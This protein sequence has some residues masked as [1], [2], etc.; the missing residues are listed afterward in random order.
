MQT[1]LIQI[2][3]FLRAV[4]MISFVCEATWLVALKLI[5]NIS[6][7]LSLRL[8]SRFGAS[9]SNAVTGWPA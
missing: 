5:V 4:W 3:Y 7:V 1:E 8:A 2:L 6:L 9:R